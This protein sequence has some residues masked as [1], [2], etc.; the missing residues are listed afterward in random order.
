MVRFLFVTLHLQVRKAT[1][2][3]MNQICITRFVRAG[4]LAS[5][6]SDQDSTIADK[7]I[8]RTL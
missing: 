2:L 7:K 8:Y 3:L 4:A 5:S 1:M 6:Q